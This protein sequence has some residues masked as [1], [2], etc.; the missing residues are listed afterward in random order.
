MQEKLLRTSQMLNIGDHILRENQF[1]TLDVL[2]WVVRGVNDPLSPSHLRDIGEA[3]QLIEAVSMSWLSTPALTIPLKRDTS[4][5]IYNT[6]EQIRGRE[7]KQYLLKNLPLAV[8]FVAA[9]Q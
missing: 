8:G 6:S 9:L 4:F 7:K 5:C 2:L 1:Q 3:G